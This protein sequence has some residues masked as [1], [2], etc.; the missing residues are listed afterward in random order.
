MTCPQ[1]SWEKLGVVYVPDGSMPWA[2]T[3]AT[4]PTP[5]VL[6]DRIRVYIQCRDALGVGR[7]GFVDVDR[8]DPRKIIFI[9]REPVLDIGLPGTFDEN[10]V[11]QTCVLA[12]PGRGH[13]LYYVGF[14]L[15]TKIRYRMLTGLAHSEDGGLTFKRMQKTPI[16][17][18]SDSELYIRGG[19]FV[20]LHNGGFRMWYV[21]GSAWETI[22]G[23]EVPVYDMR[24]VESE[25][26]VSWPASG[27]VCLHTAGEDEVGF[28]RPWVTQAD[29]M[30]QMYY[31]VRLRSRGGNY[32][33]GYALSADGKNWSR[34][35][36]ALGLVTSLSGWD[37]QAVDYSAV[38]E[39]NGQSYMFYN[40]NDYGVTGFGVAVRQ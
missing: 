4:C 5:L 13:F 15:G 27:P 6:D 33:L 36:D 9:S 23:K 20:V 30:Y 18:R 24:V 22:L 32:A 10:G 31:S 28:G 8:E 11:F 34:H 40:G 39:L 29:G 38:V 7:I 17:E 16:L 37:S 35:D 26:G 21:G 14:E 2:R 19:P 1:M 25:D 3:H 12:V